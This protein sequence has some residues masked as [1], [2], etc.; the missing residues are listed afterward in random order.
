MLV[1]RESLTFCTNSGANTVIFIKKKLT[2]VSL[3]S[4]ATLYIQ[5]TMKMLRILNS[6]K[7]NFISLKSITYKRDEKTL[8]FR[9]G[10]GFFGV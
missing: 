6:W 9:E 4:S 7:V 3:L 10:V 2:A 8:K 5:I 1:P